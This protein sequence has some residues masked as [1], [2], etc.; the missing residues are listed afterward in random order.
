MGTQVPNGAI[1]AEFQDTDIP[2]AAGHEVMKMKILAAHDREDIN[3]VISMM[4]WLSSRSGEK[5]ES[6]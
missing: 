1:L 3:K 6:C 2:Y 4:S 5:S